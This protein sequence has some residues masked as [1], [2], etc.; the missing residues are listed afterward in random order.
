MTKVN[1]TNSA[2]VVGKLLDD[3]YIELILLF[4]LNHWLKNVRR[5]NFLSSL[6]VLES[7]AYYTVVGTYIE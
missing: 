4:P 5:A 2:I 6:H 1:Q 7:L 3:E